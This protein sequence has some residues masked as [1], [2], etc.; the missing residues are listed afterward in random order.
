[1]AD[2]ATIIRRLGQPLGPAHGKLHLEIR[3]TKADRKRETRLS[4]PRRSPSLSSTF[5][6]QQTL[7]AFS[8]Q[9][10]SQPTSS[11]VSPESAD[12]EPDHS[13]SLSATS[14]SRNTISLRHDYGTFGTREPTSYPGPD[15]ASAISRLELLPHEL[16]LQIIAFLPFADIIRLRQTCRSYYTLATEDVV[17]SVIGPERFI[18][19]LLSTCR[20]CLVQDESRLNLLLD[21][22]GNEHADPDTNSF[23]HEHFGDGLDDAKTPTSA[24]SE[25][26]TSERPSHTASPLRKSCAFRPLTRCTTCLLLASDT[27]L[28]VGRKVELASLDS[29]WICRWCGWPVNGPAA[30]G[31]V[32]FHRGCYAR[33]GEILCRFFALGWVQ[34]GLGV[35]GWIIAMKGFKGVGEVKV[36]AMV[37]DSE[38]KV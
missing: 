23:A 13:H 14:V 16:Q 11:S 5:S 27:R 25:S 2:P 1:M 6:W 8:R 28:R 3:T 10:P 22:R 19:G 32:Q 37:S 33:Y 20:T 24:T 9:N 36:P 12:G 4:R 38:P 34:F 29:V 15:V 35:S 21:T 7:L 30:F 31:H 26:D 17:G 18:A